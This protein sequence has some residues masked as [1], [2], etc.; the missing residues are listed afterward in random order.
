MAEESDRAG[1]HVIA[2]RLRERSAELRQ[3][4]RE[5]R[6]LIVSIVPPRLHEEGLA[7]ALTDMTSSLASKG[8][9]VSVHVDPT[10][11]LSEASESLLFRA[12]QESVRNTVTH[13]GASHVEVSVVALA[14][15]RVRLVVRDN[16]SGIDPVDF[17]EARSG[18]HVG[19]R[20]LTELVEQAD[21]TLHVS[22]EPGVGTTITLEVAQR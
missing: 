7:A 21:G 16:G 22:S 11:H 17:A 8:I 10:I 6:T 13:A 19:L 9:G 2:D 1:G 20:L 3:W 15:E 4:V 18:G 12:A 5:L 14:A